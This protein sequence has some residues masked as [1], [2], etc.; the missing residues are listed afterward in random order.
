V[1]VQLYDYFHGIDFA[2]EG[3]SQ[4]TPMPIVTGKNAA[5]FLKNITGGKLHENSLRRIDF[6]R[7][8]KYLNPGLTKYPFDLESIFSQLQDS[9]SN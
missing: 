9:V 2:E 7:Y 4:R 3:V 1:L 5:V 6:S 8:S